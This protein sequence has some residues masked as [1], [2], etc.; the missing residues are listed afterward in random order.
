MKY[1]L[2]TLPL[3]ACVPHVDPCLRPIVEIPRCVEMDRADH[4]AFVDHDTDHGGDDGDNG[5]G[6]ASSDSVSDDSN[7]EGSDE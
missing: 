7:G 6:S 2:L 4:A 1:L 5:A 3:A